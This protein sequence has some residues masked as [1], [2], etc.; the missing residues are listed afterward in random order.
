MSV[1]NE[2]IR[3]VENALAWERTPK[4]IHDFLVQDD[5]LSEYDAYLAYQAG[6]V[7]LRMFGGTP[8]GSR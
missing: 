8:P 2:I 3:R 1:T 5:K 6:V 7:S 4:E